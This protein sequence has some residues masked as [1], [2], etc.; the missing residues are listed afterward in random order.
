MPLEMVRR[1]IWPNQHRSGHIGKC[2]A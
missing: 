2:I 1:R